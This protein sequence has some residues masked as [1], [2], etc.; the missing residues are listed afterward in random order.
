MP[1]PGIGDPYWFEWYVGLKYIIEMLN[2]DSGISCVIFQHETYQTIDDVVV[3]YENGTNQICYQVKHE[4]AT[5]K[6]NNLTFGKLLEK[7]P[8]GMCLFEAL[9]SGWKK[10]SAEKK[11]KIKPVLYTNRKILDRRAGR[12]CNGT[13]YSAYPVDKFLS[14]IQDIFEN[15]EDYSNVVIQE[16]NL[17]HQW[18]EFCSAL[19][20]EEKDIPDV[21]DFLKHFTIQANQLGL[22]ETHQEL[23]SALSSL[24]A[25]SE[26]LSKELLEKLTYA[27]QE[28]T[29]TRRKNERITKEEIFSVLGTEVDA[30]ES[31]HRLAPPFP[32]FKSRQAFC[33]VIERKVRETD[34]KVVLL[35][36]DPGSGKTST[37]SYLQSTTDLFLLRY[38]TFR[39]ISPEQ[40]F[41]NAD[42]GICSSENLWGTLLI[43]LRQKLRGKLAEYEVP[44]SNKLLT[45]E[46]MRSHVFR[47]LG[48]LALEAVDQNSHIYVC[49]DGIDHAARA[50]NEVSFLSSLPLPSEIPDGVCFVI[51]G[52]PIRLYQAQYPAWLSNEEVIEY[53]DMPKLCIEDIGQLITCELPQFREIVDGLAKFIYERTEGNNLSAVFAIEEIK[54]ASSL[55]DAIEK[56]NTSQITADIQQYYHHIWNYMKTEIL[57]MGLP[58]A[59][60]ESVI[61][62]SVLL[63]NGR[64]KTDILSEALQQKYRV[65]ETEWRQILDKLYPLI[66]PC[67]EK[68]EYAFFHNDFRIFLMGAIKGCEV[69]YKDIA[70]ALAKYLLCNEQGLLT[71]ISAIPLLQCA[72]RTD[73]VPTYFTAGFVINALAEGV[74][75]QR[76]EDFLR[77]SYE[78]ACCNQDYE[79]YT[80]TYLAAKTLYQHESYFEYY[81]RQYISNDYPEINSIDISEVRVLPARREN[82]HEY[83]RVLILCKKLHKTGTRECVERASALYAKWFGEL[84]PYSFVGLCSEEETPESEAW[85]LHTT[86]I[87]LFLQNW[88]TSAAE[89][90]LAVPVLE[91]PAS[92]KEQYALFVFGEAYFS[93]CMDLREPDMA[94]AAI[95]G[96]FVDKNCFSKNLENMLYNG[97]TDKFKLF[98]P[99]IEFNQ[100]TPSK[101]LLAMAMQV[102]CQSEPK[103]EKTQLVPFENVQSI[104]DEVSFSAVLR[105]FLLGYA[106]CIWD[107]AVICGH[108]QEFYSFLKGDDQEKNQISKL[109]RLAALLG[110]S[111]SKSRGPISDTFRRHLEWF[112]TSRL[113]RSIDYS[114]ARRFL[115]FVLFQ[116]PFVD[117][118][119][120]TEWLL[121]ALKVQL[122]EIEYIGFY[123]KAYILNYLKRHGR[124]DIIRE[125]I[126]TLYGENCSRISQEE[127]KADMHHH[128]LPYGEVVD[129]QMMKEFSDRLKWDVVGYTGHKEY[130]MQGLLDSF[131]IISTEDPKFWH[132]AGARLYQQSKIASI[133]NNECEYDI[134]EKIIS[135]AVNCGIPDFWTLHYWSEEFSM[136]PSLIEYALGEFIEQSNQIVD[137]EVLW[138]LNCGIHSWYTQND[139]FGSKGIYESCCKHAQDLGIDFK[140]V[141]ERVTPQWLNIIGYESRDKG[142]SY[143]ENDFTRRQKEELSEI[144]TEYETATTDELIAVLP[145]VPLLHHAEK[146]YELIIN[147]LISENLFTV[148]NARH[149]L[150]SVCSY[151]TGKDWTYER[152][153]SIIGN[154]LLKLGDEAFWKLAATIGHHL[155]DY[156]YQTSSRNIWILLKLYC[157]HDNE[158]IKALFEKELAVQKQWITGNN[159][160]PVEFISEPLQRKFEVP[161]NLAEMTLYILIEQVGT[162]NARK[163]ESAVFAIHKLGKYFPCLLDTIALSWDK[164]S[165]AQKEFLLPVIARW[166]SDG[167]ISKQLS[168]VVLEDYINCNSLPFKYYYHSILTKLKS[169]G[170]EK[171]QLTFEASVNGYTLPTCGEYVKNS[172]YENFLSLVESPDDARSSN[173]IRR[174]IAQFPS[175][176]LP[177]EDEYGKPEDLRIPTWNQDINNVLYGEEMSG[178]WGSSSLLSKKSL[179]IPLEDPFLLTDMPQIAY[180]EEWFPDIPHRYHEDGKKDGLSSEKLHDIVH[181]NIQSS[182]MLLAA[183]IWYPWNYKDGC[184]FYELAQIKSAYDLSSNNQD[185]YC[186]GNFG[187]LTYEGDIEES[188]IACKRYDSIN[189][190]NKVRGSIKISFG[191]GQIV[192]SSAWRKIFHCEPSDE[193]PYRW[194]DENGIEVLRFER[195]ISPIR[196]ATQE[197]YI[198]QPTLFRWICNAEWL[199]QIL[200]ELQLR[201]CFITSHETI[202]F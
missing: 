37:I 196:E 54:G 111:Y 153:D 5:S 55:E 175:N 172:T 22:I 88:G 44:V 25:C 167:I 159:H 179:L 12:I 183:C 91:K 128:F 3:E 10:A 139:R 15:V 4:I 121:I 62:C 83:E 122:F 112:L 115:I 191:N 131:E 75:K 147:R 81:E 130:A 50:N 77:I 113:W 103:I 30:N 9:F 24:F 190:F 21:V 141:V 188:H 59:F 27:L 129:P 26:S 64:V 13:K 1:N 47:L 189:L 105:S 108:T 52:Q 99:Q 184:I 49:I 136:D 94:V 169:A 143:E 120:E 8:N 43:Q 104:Y 140:N 116:S 109:A 41:Y 72:E 96:G 154:L 11:M 60:P 176:E 145:E 150:E 51:V 181:K 138:L 29:T 63:M 102:I 199:K 16:P 101:K 157:R 74:S 18:E 33:E 19:K 106:E 57:N 200:E 98:L 117:S 34:K 38:H 132:K 70:L 162:H 23:L 114:K 133:S 134:C 166:I 164:I 174:Y 195:T 7:K 197:A 86:E 170:I 28:W 56:L 39:P 124:L 89:L 152:Y 171:N 69:L 142:Y 95:E 178:R 192:P 84:S 127:N 149:V 36:G 180:D 46:G 90:S 163:I 87:G 85:K 6:P 161:S 2:P 198:R 53:L 185:D 125:Y 17:L 160:I 45:L 194:V 193:S 58:V 35:S 148:D 80:N 151:I 168:D 92:Q 48:R 42:P 107:D 31:Q 68:G 40:R 20:I 173:D 73:L 118:L 82:L 123:Y 156:N 76:L 97:F 201:V 14:L 186:A 93:K 67:G 61:A 144:C 202:P 155:C 32:F 66:I 182:E 177:R 78:A 187:L 158:Q 137:L 79:G 135:A 65:S 71:Y 119:A 126:L 146:R 110:K 165:M 100:D